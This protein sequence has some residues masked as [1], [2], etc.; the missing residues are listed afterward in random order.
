MNRDSS[1]CMCSK[2]FSVWKSR[3]RNVALMEN[4]TLIKAAEN[5]VM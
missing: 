3:N 5:L 2:F 4:K 1:V